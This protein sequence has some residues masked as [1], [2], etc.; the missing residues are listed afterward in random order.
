ME[1]YD[2]PS[3]RYGAAFYKEDFYD[4]MEQAGIPEKDRLEIVWRVTDAIERELSANPAE[5]LLHYIGIAQQEWRSQIKEYV[6]KN[7]NQADVQLKKT[8]GHVL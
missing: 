6:A 4:D 8:A 3:I 7:E 1:K 5:N 2:A